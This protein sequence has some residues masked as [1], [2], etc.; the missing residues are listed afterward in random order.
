LQVD[1]SRSE[2]R[3][4][5]MIALVASFV[6][7]A[8]GQRAQG[9]VELDDASFAK[10]SGIWLVQ[11]YAPWCGH[12]KQ[13]KPAYDD[14]AFFFHTSDAVSVGKIDATLYQGLDAYAAGFPTLILFRDSVILAK[15]DGPRT[16]PDMIEFVQ[17]IVSPP[18]RFSVAEV[19]FQLRQ[20]YK[21]SMPIWGYLRVYSLPVRERIIPVLKALHASEVGSFVV[22]LLC[23]L[24]VVLGCLWLVRAVLRLLIIV[25][26]RVVH[27][28]RPATEV[29]HHGRKGKS[30]HRPQKKTQ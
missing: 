28:R 26:Q 14:V 23:M 20:L 25:V 17:R 10:R 16:V 12:C 22:G 15:Y 24:A 21:R 18:P 5:Q 13:L 8:A 27:G 29:E 3:P 19:N 1:A 7:L 9:V 4:E 6:L 2:T 11:F 30:H